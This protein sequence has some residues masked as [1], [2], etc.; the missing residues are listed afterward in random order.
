M[1][2]A[3]RLG[4]GVGKW[5]FRGGQQYRERQWCRVLRVSVALLRRADGAGT[6]LQ[7]VLG[8]QPA[9]PLR[10][11]GAGGARFAAG[12][13]SSRGQSGFETCVRCW[14]CGI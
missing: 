1:P 12:R 4:G 5:E 10:A 14:T 2:G 8:S 3:T 11:P 7:H 6:Y 9:P 13:G